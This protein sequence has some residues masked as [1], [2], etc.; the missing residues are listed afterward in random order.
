MTPDSPMLVYGSA[1]IHIRRRQRDAPASPMPVS[2][3][4]T[5]NQEDLSQNV[6]TEPTTRYLT[7]DRVSLDGDDASAW[8]TPTTSTFAS[9]K[10]DDDIVYPPRMARATTPPYISPSLRTG[11]P[12]PGQSPSRV[13][14]PIGRP[15][16]L[17]VRPAL[18]P[19]HT[20]GSRIQV[21]FVNGSELHSP[22]RN[23][24]TSTDNTPTRMAQ[25]E[26][27]LVSL[28]S[29]VVSGSA[30][31]NAAFSESTEAAHDVG[32]AVNTH[33][34]DFEEATVARLWERRMSE[35]TLQDAR[36]KIIRTLLSSDDLPRD[37][38]DA[39]EERSSRSL[40]ED[41]RDFAHSQSLAALEGWRP[42]TKAIASDVSP[43]H[44]PSVR[45]GQSLDVSWQDVDRVV[46]ED[47]PISASNSLV[48]ESA[49]PSVVR[50]FSANAKF[51][52]KRSNSPAPPGF[53][54]RPFPSLAPV[55]TASD[56]LSRRRSDGYEI[57]AAVD[58]FERPM[59]MKIN[60]MINL[61][62]TSSK[63][64]LLRDGSASSVLRTQSLQ[65]LE[66]TG[67]GSPSV[68]YVCEYSRLGSI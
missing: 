36:Q 25:R 61:S 7:S 34:L 59:N 30:A 19:R 14:T 9:P 1:P 6:E 65:V 58:S 45:R 53:V 12:S 24:S 8:R 68:K 3:G 29:Q 32:S 39:I 35:R 48:R 22:P 27:S 49:R 42:P 17:A 51:V 52:P 64:P 41:A 2:T 54:D 15:S 50:R 63:P 60:S 33:E 57:G 44:R 38:R 55:Q 56:F 11:S 62:T 67:P 23:E 21:T 5:F 46:E 18:R 43:R 40:S 13:R 28:R 10:A 16:S 37:L 47:E 66:F 20:T 26:H 4:S 31:S